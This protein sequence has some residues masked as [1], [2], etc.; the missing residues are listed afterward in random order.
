MSELQ[1]YGITDPNELCWGDSDVVAISYG[2]IDFYFDD[3]RVVVGLNR[4]QTCRLFRAMLHGPVEVA[5]A[6]IRV[7]VCNRGYVHEDDHTDHARLVYEDLYRGVRV[8]RPECRAYILGQL[9]LSTI[10]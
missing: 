10:D 3:R 9:E 4:D 6:L 8:L 7:E 1:R 2:Y 5:M